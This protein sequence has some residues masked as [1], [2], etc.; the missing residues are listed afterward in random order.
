MVYP[1]SYQWESVLHRCLVIRETCISHGP[2]VNT[3][4]L[5]LYLQKM[6]LQ[7]WELSLRV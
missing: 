3:G 5:A 4:L 2:A 7:C 1:F 6:A